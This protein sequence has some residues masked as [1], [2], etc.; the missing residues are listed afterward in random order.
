L[1]FCLVVHPALTE[2][3]KQVVAEFPD[4]TLEG[5][6]KLFNFYLDDGYVVAKHA[7]LI[8]L[9]KLL[10]PHGILLDG[11][12]SPGISSSLVKKV[13][14]LRTRMQVLGDFQDTQAALLILHVCMGACCAKFLLCALPQPLV[15]YASDVFDDLMQETF[16]SISCAVLPDRVWTWVDF[17]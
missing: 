4:L 3:A 14:Y 9:G 17:R 2:V 13:E 5:V 10:A 11:F 7:V 15:K 1:L 8:R 6:F 16:A 12:P